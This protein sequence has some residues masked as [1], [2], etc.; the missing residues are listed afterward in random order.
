MPWHPNHSGKE[1]LGNQL[2][3]EGEAVKVTNL[4][5]SNTE[6]GIS[7]VLN[8]SKKKKKA[9]KHSHGNR[10]QMASVLVVVI[11][12]S[13][14][15]QAGEAR[16]CSHLSEG[17]FSAEVLTGKR[18]KGEKRDLLSPGSFRSLPF[19]SVL[20]CEILIQSAVVR[21]NSQHYLKKKKNTPTFIFLLRNG[22]LF[23]D[24]ESFGRPWH[25]I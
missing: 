9:F 8:W 21:R 4:F 16:V 19:V 11:N 12:L 7:F 22:I 6:K 2:A 3:T 5:S 24:D 23:L 14:V 1:D 10:L 18:R 15:S 25:G 13:P 20:L 17:T